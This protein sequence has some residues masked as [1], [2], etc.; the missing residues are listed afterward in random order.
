MGDFLNNFNTIL[1]EDNINTIEKQL[2]DVKILNDEIRLKLIDSDNSL[3]D[4]Y[5]SCIFTENDT[6][7]VKKETS[8]KVKNLL[9]EFSQYNWE[10]DKVSNFVIHLKTD[11]YNYFHNRLKNFYT[12]LLDK[13]KKYK[14]IYSDIINNIMKN[15]L[16]YMEKDKIS[17]EIIN[18]FTMYKDVVNK[19]FSKMEKENKLKYN[20]IK[21]LLYLYNTLSPHILNNN[22]SQYKTTK[23][24][25]NIGFIR[26][27]ENL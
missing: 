8:K 9:E 7:R 25:R 18:L 17:K 14:K 23:I 13:N 22:I 4:Y 3:F 27:Q 10:I 1:E 15:Y 6:K 21:F 12:T 11:N 5:T 2:P 20:T 19:I 26:I 16:K 24:K